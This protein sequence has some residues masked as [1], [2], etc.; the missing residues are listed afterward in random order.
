MRIVLLAAVASLLATSVPAQSADAAV[1]S[2][3][4]T[5]KW[6]INYDSDSCH[7]VAG[8]GEGADAIFLNITRF[9]P[10]DAFDLIL[11]GEAFN[12]KAMTMPVELAFGDQPMRDKQFAIAGETGKKLPLVIIGGQSL[13]DWKSATTPTQEAAVTSVSIRLSDGKT[14]RLETGSLGPAMAALRTCTTDLVARWGYDPAVQAALRSPAVPISSPAN[15]VKTNDYPIVSLRAGHN[16]LVQ[17]RLDLDEKGSVQGCH[18]LMRFNP[19]EFA[20][21]TCNLLKK[22][23]TFKP[24]VDAQGNPVKTYFVNKVRF[25]IPDY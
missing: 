21:L 18:V 22:R 11:Y 24:A 23:A 3:A 5:T 7:L 2:L 1:V 6:E 4:K 9:Q 20:D 13:D 15:W 12:T 8:F 10:S 25:V 14:F 16:G 19:D 17:F